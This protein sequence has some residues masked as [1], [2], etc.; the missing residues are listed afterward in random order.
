MGF[1][2]LQKLKRSAILSLLNQ[3][4]LQKSILLALNLEILLVLIPILYLVI[5][6]FTIYKLVI[7]NISNLFK[8]LLIVLTI[9]FPVLGVLISLIYLSAFKNSIIIK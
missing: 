9:F 7:A 4:L 2:L 3:I 8:T 6:V 1:K 5:L